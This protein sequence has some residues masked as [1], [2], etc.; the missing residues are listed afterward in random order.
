MNEDLK[1]QSNESLL[2]FSSAV[3]VHTMYIYDLRAGE[4]TKVRRLAVATMRTERI[5]RNFVAYVGT[6][7]TLTTEVFENTVLPTGRIVRKRHSSVAL[8]K[9]AARPQGSLLL[10]R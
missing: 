9:T 2:Y 7:E 1:G 6:S 5:K 8:P 4:S 10:F 3:L